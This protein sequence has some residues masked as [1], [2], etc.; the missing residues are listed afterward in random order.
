MYQADKILK[1]LEEGRDLEVLS[2]E[3]KTLTLNQLQHHRLVE[4]TDGR[5]HL[6]ETG[7]EALKIGAEKFVAR[8]KA[9]SDIMELSTE[10]KEN[11]GS[12]L[13]LSLLLLLLLTILF[14]LFNLDYLFQ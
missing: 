3:N 5:F 2:L 12:T 4:V 14:F 6:T 10:K 9:E 1:M 7:R 11:R 13:I 8:K